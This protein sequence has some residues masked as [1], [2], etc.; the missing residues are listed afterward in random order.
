MAIGIKS[1]FNRYKKQGL[2][3]T[4]AM[5]RA[6]NDQAKGIAKIRKADA[7]AAKKKKG[8]WVS[9]LKRDIA[10]LKGPGH[11][12]AGKKYSKRKY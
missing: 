1:S 7:A 4:Q 3:D 11:S 2:T 8:S 5:E 10:S 9:R 12:P 6:M